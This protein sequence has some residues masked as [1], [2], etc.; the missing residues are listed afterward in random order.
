[1]LINHCCYLHAKLSHFV[2]SP[3]SKGQIS[4]FNMGQKVI[5]VRITEET[6]E[7]IQVTKG[8]YPEN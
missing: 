7:Q 2:N 8:I 6:K 1:M 3:T 5:T 4:N